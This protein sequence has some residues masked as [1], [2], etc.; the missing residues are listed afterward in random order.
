MS[1][2]YPIESVARIWPSQILDKALVP[3]SVKYTLHFFSDL[4]TTA[5][6]HMCSGN[7]FGDSPEVVT[8]VR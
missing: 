8:L 4:R 7:S 2:Y 1:L 3:Y 6:L 5:G